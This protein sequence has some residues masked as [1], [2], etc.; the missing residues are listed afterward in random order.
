MPKVFVK[1]GKEKFEL[2]A[3]PAEMPLLFKSQLFGLTGVPP[4]RQKVMIKV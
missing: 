3:D 1:W 4:E 2:E